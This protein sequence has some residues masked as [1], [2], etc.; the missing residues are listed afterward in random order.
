MKRKAEPKVANAYSMVVSPLRKVAGLIGSLAARSDGLQLLRVMNEAQARGNDEAPVNSA[1]TTRQ[2]EPEFG[3]TATK[4]RCGSS[5][6]R[7]L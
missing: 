4:R 5:W 6:R 1:L 2:A 3:P 7:Q